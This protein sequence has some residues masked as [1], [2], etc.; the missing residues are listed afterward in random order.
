[1][2][3]LLSD[4][5]GTINCPRVELDKVNETLKKVKTLI[6]II[7]IHRKWKHQSAFSSVRYGHWRKRITI[8]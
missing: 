4:I 7:K 1:M 5:K 8:A 6:N 2:E 3:F